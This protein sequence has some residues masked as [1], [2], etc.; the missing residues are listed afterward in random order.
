[1]SHYYGGVQGNRGEAT[2]GGSRDSGY[3]AWAQDGDRQV[4]TTLYTCED[5][6]RTRARVSVRASSINY[7][8]IETVVLF[9]GFLDEAENS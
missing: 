8:H 4:R 7:G 5:T 6:G 1:M 9:D 3:T 2:R